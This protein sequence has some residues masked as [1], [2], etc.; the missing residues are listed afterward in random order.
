MRPL[1][2]SCRARFQHGD[3]EFISLALTGAPLD[4]SSIRSLLGEPDTLGLVLER[5]QLLRAVLELSEPLRISPE[6]YFFV[7]VRHNLKE[8]GIDDVGVA[9]YVAATLAENARGNPLAEREA[10]SPGTSF[11]YQIDFLEELDGGSSY[12]RFFLQV[13]CGNHFLV[14]TSLFPSFLRRRSRRSGAPGVR[15]YDGVARNAFLAARDHPLAE[16]F[17]LVEVYQRLAER[18]VETRRALNRMAEEYLF[19]R[20]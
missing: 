19:L 14:M 8:A 6:L 5:P 16:E 7:L 17:A 4:E 1:S 2:T 10:R 11:N 18:F 15:Y 12:D 13:Q 3:F 9:D 20:A